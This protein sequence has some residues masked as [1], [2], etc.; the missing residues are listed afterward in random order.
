[1]KKSSI[2]IAILIISI[3]LISGCG[4]KREATHKERLISVED[5]YYLTENNTISVVTDEF[6]FKGTPNPHA[7]LSGEW[8]ETSETYGFIAKFNI[9]EI[10]NVE[11]AIL[12]LKVEAYTHK[13]ISKE[14]CDVT[15]L[16]YIK[17]ITIK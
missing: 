4:G 1:M 3:L 13:L 15:K 2:L 11:N 7:Y 6:H 16:F 12:N 5:K 14:N 8:L 10:K 17:N 9:S